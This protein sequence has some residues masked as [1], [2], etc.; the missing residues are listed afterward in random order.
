MSTLFCI[1]FG[2]N[3]DFVVLSHFWCLEG[4]EGG[5]LV[6][7]IVVCVYYDHVVCSITSLVPKERK[8]CWRHLVF[9]AF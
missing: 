8:K 5:Q 6:T 1:L 4:R 2:Q 7:F 3:F 9:D